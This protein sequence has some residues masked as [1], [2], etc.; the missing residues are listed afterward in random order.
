MLGLRLTPSRVAGRPQG[1]V[2]M[3]LIIPEHL[4]EIEYHRRYDRDRREH[5]HTEVVDDPGSVL[6]HDPAKLQEWLVRCTRVCAEEYLR[7]AHARA[8]E[9]LVHVYRLLDGERRHVVSIRMRWDGRRLPVD[10]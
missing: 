4:H 2:C 3:S 10:E 8:G 6:V 9:W 5:V 1:M 7:R